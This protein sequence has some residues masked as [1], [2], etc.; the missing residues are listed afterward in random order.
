MCRVKGSFLSYPK[1][2]HRMCHDHG[3]DISM[4]Q[5]FPNILIVSSAEVI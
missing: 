3:I 4:R 2:A 5:A 1:H